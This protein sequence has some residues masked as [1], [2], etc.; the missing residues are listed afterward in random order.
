[1][2]KALF[3]NRPRVQWFF[4][5]C[6]ALLAVR[7][8]WWTLFGSFN[9]D[10]F[11]NFQVLWAILHNSWPFRDFIY[12]H[13]P[14][15]N[16]LLYPI[17]AAFGTGADILIWTRLALLPAQFL[18]LY[19]IGQIARRCNGNPSA[20]WI[21]VSL[22][23]ASPF[24]AMNLVEVRHDNLALPL[25]LGGIIFGFDYLRQTKKSALT[26]ALSAGLF[27]LSL[28]FSI[29]SIM[30]ILMMALV[31]EG[32]AVRDFKEAF[33]RRVLRLLIYGGVVAL[34]MAICA[35]LMWAAGILDGR[36]LWVM[37]TSG[38]LVLIRADRFSPGSELVWSRLLVHPVA[39]L[40]GL[41]FAM[42]LLFSKLKTH[43]WEYKYLAGVAISAFFQWLFLWTFIAQYAIVPFLFFCLVAGIWLANR[44]PAQL[45]GL[46][47][48]AVV[49]ANLPLAPR[50]Y[51]TRTRQLE[52]FS[53]ILNHFPLE[54][55]LLDSFSG[56]SC[57]H[58][59]IGRDL[60]YRPMFFWPDFYQAQNE[61]VVAALLRKK[62]G[63]V[64]VDGTQALYPSSVRRIIEFNYQ[65]APCAGVLEPKP[66]F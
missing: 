38:H 34:P 17:L 15:F 24:I 59:F 39:A 12:N 30:A 62:Y 64:I 49:V 44:V 58:S 5:G 20:P 33:G 45:I 53:C 48:L 40:I 18:S 7:Q 16:L 35:A 50:Y 63:G 66:D 52:K 29:K 41:F 57:F 61:T 56:L 22:F 60:Y 2:G 26:L 3:N 46:F 51:E 55:P 28:L 47:L 23:L 19:L 8:L 43:R 11:E 6:A 9:V 4:M 25:V 14:A 27:G 42:Q 10:E 1:M 36:Q 37:L 65:P 13:P 21:A 31:M 54:T 32:Q